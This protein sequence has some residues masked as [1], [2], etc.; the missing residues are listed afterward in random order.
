[1]R[2]DDAEIPI[3][4]RSYDETLNLVR[5]R[6]KDGALEVCFLTEAR[7]LF[8]LTS[9]TGNLVSD[10]LKIIYAARE[11]ATRPQRRPSLFCPLGLPQ[12][13]N[14]PSPVHRQDRFGSGRVPIRPRKALDIIADVGGA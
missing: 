1:M 9:E 4:S 6:G 14:F 11:R 13:Y 7:A 10:G 8:K 12:H 5:F 3:A 2:G